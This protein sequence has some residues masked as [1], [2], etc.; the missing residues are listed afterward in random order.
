[1]NSEKATKFEKKLCCWANVKTKWEIVSN[2]VT[3]SENLNFAL[4]QNF[5]IYFQ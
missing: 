2:I 5:Q 4:S 1:M 3:F